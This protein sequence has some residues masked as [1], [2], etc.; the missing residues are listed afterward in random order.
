MSEPIDPLM[1]NNTKTALVIE[2][3]AMRSIFSAGLLDG[4]IRQK[5]NPFDFYI[6]VSAGAYNLIAY[7]SGEPEISLN[8]FRDFASSKQFIN[9]KRFLMGGH[10]IDLDWIEKIAF[11]NRVNLDAVYHQNKKVFVCLTDVETGKAVYVPTQADNIRS[12]IKA[13]AALPLLY[14]H[15]PQINNRD[16]VDG[17]VADGIPVGEAIRQ[18][19][20]KIMVIRARPKCYQKKDTI[21]HRLIRWKLREHTSLVNTMRER[22]MIYQESLELIRNPPDGVQVI[23]INPPEK[24]TLGRFNRNQAALLKGYDAGITQADNAIAKWLDTSYNL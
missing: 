1:K 10:L 22:V 15:F 12:T 2:G 7:L 16:M 5:F 14:R 18:G 21:N 24:L 4:F 19:A 13:S 8:I 11:N 20:K 9:F 17:G 23:E 3:G 6:G